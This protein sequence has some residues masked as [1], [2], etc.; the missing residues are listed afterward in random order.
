MTADYRAELQRLLTAVEND[1]IDTND[2]PRFQAAVDRAHAA[3]T[4]PEPEGVTD[5]AWQEFIEQVQHVQHVALREGQGPRFDLVE[6]ALALWGEAIPP[7]PEPLAPLID[8]GNERLRLVAAGIRS[9]YMAGHDATVDGHYGDPDEVASEMAE[10]VIDELDALAQP[11][12]EGDRLFHWRNLGDGTPVQIQ[13]CHMCGIAPTNVDDCGRFGDPACPCFG[14]GKPEPEGPTDEEIEEWHSHC[15]YLTRSV[16]NGGA[17]TGDHYWAFD[18]ESDHVASIVR[19]ALA[20]W[21]RPTIEPV[22]VS[23]RPW[24]R[25]GWCDLDGECWWR[26]P[27]SAVLQHCWVMVNPA[28]VDAGWLLP[29]HA[30]PIPAPKGCET[31][32]HPV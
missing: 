22:P 12:P 1:V 3:L 29:A 14:V 32:T 27:Y 9:G 20:R 18:V 11:E 17:G 25:E 16:D 19:A 2:G 15:A 13:E 21:G 30:L 24:E 4:Q 6:C 10:V 7:A 31:G 26:P 8:A 28:R 5:E 23:E